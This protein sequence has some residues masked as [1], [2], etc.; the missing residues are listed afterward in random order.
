MQGSFKQLAT[1]NSELFVGEVL[2]EEI[3][4]EL[5]TKGI[6]DFDIET[7]ENW[8]GIWS[9]SDLP[10][11]GTAQLEDI[12]GNVIGTVSWVTDFRVEQEMQGRVIRAYVKSYKL[13][14]SKGE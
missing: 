4:S 12:N 13:D 3:R 8:K 5:N 9:D 14:L 2:K 11:T 1:A 7:P 6:K 10:D